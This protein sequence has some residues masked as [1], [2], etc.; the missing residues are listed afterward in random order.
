MD[1]DKEERALKMIYQGTADTLA[2]ILRSL[3]PADFG[4]GKARVVREKVD[5]LIGRLDRAAQAWARRA[6][7][8]AYREQRTVTENRLAILGR[9]KKARDGGTDRHA[10][11][12][13]K[14]VRLTLKDLWKA[15]ATMATTAEQYLG[16]LD[17]SRR[18]LE[19]LQA[20]S[21]ADAAKIADLA[22]AAV[23]E[24]LARHELKKQVLEVLADRL[25]GRDFIVVKGRRYRAGKY[26]ELV[27]RTELREAASDATLTSAK[28]YDHD[29]VEI[30]SKGGSCG[31]CQKIEGKTYS[32]SGKTPG[33]PVL[34]EDVTPPL[35]PNCVLPGT[36]CVSPGG[37]IAGHRARYDG[38]AV[39][40]TLA[41]GRRLSVTPNHM[42]MTRQGFAPANL[43]RQGDEI[44]YCPSLERV[45]PVHPDDHEF[46][47]LAED[48]FGALRESGRMS[49]GGMPVSSEDLHG[50]GRF[51]DGHVDVVWSDRLLGNAGEA[52]SPEPSC[53]VDFSGADIALFGLSGEG[54][55][56]AV[57]KTLALSA[58]SLVGGIRSA[59]PLFRRRAGR[60]HSS[61]LGEGPL[62]QAEAREKKFQAAVDDLIRDSEMARQIGFEKPAL[63]QPQKLVRVDVF[64]YHGF[65]YDF[66]TPE[67]LYICNGMVSSNCEHY[68]RVVS[69]GSL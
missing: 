9:K 58:D 55:L 47:T 24:G 30:P 35:H 67:S 52:H 59:S 60:G 56:A 31:D 1:R 41:N 33:F 65:V 62:G 12:L 3:D 51:C 44:L 36:G 39:E 8:A 22:D 27:A 68:L 4:P 53:E 45:V 32:I 5:R 19:R 40:L 16:L 14:R 61:D 25:K 28:D 11:A 23:E 10:R 6:L 37:F 43:L 34:T 57:L 20:M 29:L 63:I 17:E 18:G 26:A 66:Q 50:D 21:K 54:D 48:I 42:L 7:G 46:P 49:F 2:G 38:Q 64:S 15:N 69:R 13:A